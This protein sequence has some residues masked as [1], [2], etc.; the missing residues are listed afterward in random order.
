M[1]TKPDTD[2]IISSPELGISLSLSLSQ[3]TDYL[4]DKDYSPRTI[5]RYSTCIP[6][7][8]LWL[9]TRVQQSNPT[10][11]PRD[12]GEYRRYLID[13]GYS[14]S[15]TNQYL[16]AIKTYSKWQ[17]E[18]EQVE[19]DWAG[20]AKLI[21]IQ[22]GVKMGLTKREYHLLMRQVESDTCTVTDKAVFALLLGCGLRREAA[23]DVLL[24]DLTFHPSPIKPTGMV[25]VRDGK[26]GRA[27][28]V[29]FQGWVYDMLKDAFEARQKSEEAAEKSVHRIPLLNLKGEGVRAVVERWGKRAGLDLHCHLLRRTFGQSMR[30]TRSIETVKRL[31]GHSKL[32]TT[33]QY[34]ETPDGTYDD[35]PDLY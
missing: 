22:Y 13:K 12:V 32:D 24:T 10:P 30:K 16:S 14:S 8:F 33:A 20:M 2:T 4:H 21:N 27:R 1:N 23:P 11:L 18:T 17:V 15:T 29:P 31:M 35:V 19:T 5:K 7:F 28:E 26:G 3:F 9:S 25:W 34:T 6:S